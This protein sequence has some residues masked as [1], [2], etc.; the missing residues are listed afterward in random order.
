[1]FALLQHVESYLGESGGATP[2]LQLIVDGLTSIG[3]PLVA[4]GRC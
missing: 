4:S 2:R 3:R 1:M